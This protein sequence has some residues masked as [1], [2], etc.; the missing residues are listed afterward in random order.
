M[1]TMVANIPLCGDCSHIIMSVFEGIGAS[2]KICLQTNQKC[3]TSRSQHAAG[4]ELRKYQRGATTDYVKYSMVSHRNV[5]FAVLRMCK[6]RNVALLNLI[7]PWL[8]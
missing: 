7:S 3:R 4:A 1:E 5:L 6:C 2:L 8:P